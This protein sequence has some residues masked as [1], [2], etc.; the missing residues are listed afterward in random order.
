LKKNVYF[1]EAFYKSKAFRGKS[2]QTPR[3]AKGYAGG[4][5]A[6]SKEVQRYDFLVNF[7]SLAKNKF[8]KFFP[9]PSAFCEIYS[10]SGYRIIV[11]ETRRALSLRQKTPNNSARFIARKRITRIICLFR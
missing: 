4:G 6:S 2:R 10:L 3:L 11:V 8:S 7:L 1:A 9:A 5:D